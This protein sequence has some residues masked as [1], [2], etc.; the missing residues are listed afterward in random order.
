MDKESKTISWSEPTHLGGNITFYELKIEA[1]IDGVPYETIYRLKNHRC[2]LESL[3][4]RETND[5]RIFVR[6]V[7]V[8]DAEFELNWLTVIDANETDVCASDEDLLDL[9]DYELLPG[10]WSEYSTSCISHKLL[11][12]ASLYTFLF[13]LIFCGSFGI[14]SYLMYNEYIRCSSLEVEVPDGLKE[15][16]PLDDINAKKTD[17]LFKRLFPRRH[18]PEGVTQQTPDIIFVHASNDYTQHSIMRESESFIDETPHQ[19]ERNEVLAPL[20]E[21]PANFRIDLQPIDETP[22]RHSRDILIPLTP[23]VADQSNSTPYIQMTA[24]EHRPIPITPPQESMTGDYVPIVRGFTQ[25]NYVGTV[26]QPTPRNFIKDMLKISQL[27]QREQQT[28][29]ETS[30]QQTRSP[31]VSGNFE[32][33]RF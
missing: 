9:S 12:M 7:N 24:L 4:A 6:A 25:T 31:E 14:A 26:I 10:E 3:C 33:L 21:A 30:F 16:Y 18:R 13:I 28:P 8:I 15:I 1:T 17:S 5:Y 27:Q 22:E 32:D 29:G 20:L 19:N 11:S 2:Q 23:H